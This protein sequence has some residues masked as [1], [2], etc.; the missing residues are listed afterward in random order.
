MPGRQSRARACATKDRSFGY[1]MIKGIW[2]LDA[3]QAARG[4][5][6]VGGFQCDAEAAVTYKTILVHCDAGKSVTS[7]LDVAVGLT[8]RFNAHLVALH[9]RPPFQP[10]AFVESG[11]DLLLDDYEE[12]VKTS[13]S[14]AAAAFTKAIDGKEIASEWRAVDGL[15]DSSLI[16]HARY[17]DLVIVGQNDPDATTVLPVPSDLPETVALSTGRAVLVVPHIGVQKTPGGT[18]LL[19]WNASRES[20]RAASEALP[21]LKA[22]KQV[23]VLIV[24]SKTGDNPGAEPGASVAAWLSRH[25]VKVTVQRDSSADADAGSAILSHAADH[26]ADLIVMGIYG[27][28]R[29]RELVLG[30]ASR[31]LLSSMTAPVLMAH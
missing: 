3:D 4:L 31:T 23:I 28:S 16:A 10:P 17:A 5:Y 13:Q 20:A 9:A 24:G 21:L 30:G 19:C 2:Q 22:A 11:M 6:F 27:H 25:G 8:Q 1:D 12:N 18:V 26:D 29:W 15:A 7:R 14:A